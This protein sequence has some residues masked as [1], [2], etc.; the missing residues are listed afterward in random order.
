MYK[1]VGFVYSAVGG[2]NS[3][4]KQETQGGQKIFFSCLY[5]VTFWFFLCS[6]ESPA[7]Q[8]IHRAS[9]TPAVASTRRA[10]WPWQRPPP[11]PPT[12]ATHSAHCRPPPRSWTIPNMGKGGGCR[13]PSI[14]LPSPS[15][16][17]KIRVFLKK[18]SE[19]I[20]KSFFFYFFAPLGKG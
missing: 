13:S 15:L 5:L 19:P 2:L 8:H 3:N 20:K 6:P 4:N 7:A 1:N 14:Q 12:T 18:N 10:V 9:T 17:P 11:P 16:L